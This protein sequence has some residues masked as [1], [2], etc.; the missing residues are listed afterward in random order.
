MPL[1]FTVRFV[2]S[3]VFRPGILSRKLIR[4]RWPRPY[5]FRIKPRFSARRNMRIRLI[6]SSRRQTDAD[7]RN[8]S[9]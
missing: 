1:A 2:S 3:E 5:L 6:V 7:C 4:D 8:Y 9:A